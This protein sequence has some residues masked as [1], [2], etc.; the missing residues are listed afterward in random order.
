MS[1][2]STTALVGTITNTGTIVVNSGSGDTTILN[3]G[4]FAAPDVTLQGGGTIDLVT[5][6]TNAAAFLNPSFQ[7]AVEHFKLPCFSV[8]I[9]EHPNLGT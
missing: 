4:D 3:L 6:S 1:G 5:A 2:S 7:F 9:G 8:K